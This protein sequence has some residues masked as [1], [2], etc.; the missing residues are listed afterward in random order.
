MNNTLANNTWAND[1]WAN[2][3]MALASLR[4]K[5]VRVTPLPSEPLKGKADRKLALLAISGLLIVAVSCIALIIGTGPAEAANIQ[6][7]TAANALSAKQD[8][9]IG[10]IATASIAFVAFGALVLFSAKKI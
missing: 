2:D 9:S 4:A 10:G 8:A 5:T 7:F 1:T 3:A 6:V